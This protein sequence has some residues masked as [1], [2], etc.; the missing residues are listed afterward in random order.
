[1]GRI[2]IHNLFRN[3]G[4]EF[5]EAALKPMLEC[6][7]LTSVDDLYLA[8]G[9][10]LFPAYEMFED[11]FYNLPAP[12]GKVV[13]SLPRYKGLVREYYRSF[14]EYEMRYTGAPPS[15]SPADTRQ[16]GM[17]G[18]LNLAVKQAKAEALAP[19]AAAVAVARYEVL[20]RHVDL[21]NPRLAEDERLRRAERLLKAYNRV[22]KAS[23][24]FRDTGEE[25][26]AARRIRMADFRERKRAKLQ[27]PE[28]A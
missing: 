28:A 11:V 10:G 5:S 15:S 12:K 27:A 23:P 8:M 17:R 7:D 1:L 21:L 22:R 24:D 25:L 16:E 2:L 13:A 18:D 14:L 26:R 20:A 6:F 19:M 9:S 3:E 4:M